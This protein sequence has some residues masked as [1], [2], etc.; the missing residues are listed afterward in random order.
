[1]FETFFKAFDGY[2][3]S[4]ASALSTQVQADIFAA[5]AHRHP[6][7]M[8]GALSDAGAVPPG[9]YRTLVEE[10]NRGLPQ[11]H[12]YFEVRR[13]LLGLPDMHYYDIY[14]PL[15]RLDKTFSLSETR[16][17]TLASVA[18]LGKDYVD[19]LA[20]ATASPWADYLPRKNKVSGAYMN[21]DAYDVHP[22]LLLN[23]TGNF[24]S[25]STF[26]HEWATPCTRC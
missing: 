14:P 8:E 2:K 20:R 5:K 25:V 15:A 23:L 11:L 19:T 16:L 12:R 6:S 4:L 26:A 13:R 1:M 3:T 7:A 9:V 24:E 17:L 10:T 18:P 22:F 21:G